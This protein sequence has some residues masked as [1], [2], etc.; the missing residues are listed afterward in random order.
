MCL[1]MPESAL[2]YSQLEHTATIDAYK[3]PQVEEV[4]VD[5]AKMKVENRPVEL[6]TSVGSSIARCVYDSIHKCG[7]FS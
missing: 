6:M 5:T 3:Y 2:A 1:I 4:R 7:G